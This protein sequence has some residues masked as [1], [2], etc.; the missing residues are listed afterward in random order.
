MFI[1]QGLHNIEK[2]YIQQAFLKIVSKGNYL[3]DDLYALTTRVVRKTIKLAGGNH[4]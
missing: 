4:M 1:L 3:V 2:T